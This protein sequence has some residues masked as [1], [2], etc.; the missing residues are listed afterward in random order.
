MKIALFLLFSC[1]I[2]SS[3][4][5]KDFFEVS[6]LSYSS[7]VIM[8]SILMTTVFDKALIIQGEISCWSVLGLKWFKGL[9]TRSWCNWT[10]WVFRELF[11]WVSCVTD[12]LIVLHVP[13][14]CGRLWIWIW[15]WLSCQQLWLDCGECRC[16]G[17]LL[18]RREVII[19]SN[20]LNNNLLKW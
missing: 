13:K 18:Q 16:K 7:S 5:G 3:K 6:I 19:M 14:G 20:N 8:S 10:H 11:F 17:Y 1:I 2:T 4:L 15:N 12:L 9:I